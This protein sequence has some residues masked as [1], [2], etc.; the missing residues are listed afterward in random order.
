MVFLISLIHLRPFKVLGHKTVWRESTCGVKKSTSYGNQSSWPFHVG[1]ENR[2]QMASGETAG[3]A[4]RQRL[5][6]FHLRLGTFLGSSSSF[7][8]PGCCCYQQMAT[9]ILYLRVEKLV[10]LSG[11]MLPPSLTQLL[12][13]AVE[14][15][16]VHCNSGTH[17]L[18]IAITG[19]SLD[20]VPWVPG[21]CKILSFYVM[22]PVNF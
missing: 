6:F 15:I 20:R 14:K 19:L 17:K 16:Q 5:V 12:G 3:L 1:V 21:T 18:S 2:I 10:C 9:F 13:V 11:A 7:K 22:A 8:Q 4:T